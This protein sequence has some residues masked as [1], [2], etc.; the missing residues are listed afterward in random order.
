VFICNVSAEATG[1]IAI[2]MAA[3]AGS[4]VFTRYGRHVFPYGHSTTAS[5]LEKTQAGNMRKFLAAAGIGWLRCVKAN[6]NVTV[7]IFCSAL[8]YFAFAVSPTGAW[9]GHIVPKKP[10]PVIL[11]DNSMWRLQDIH[12]VGVV[13]RRVPQ[14]HYARIKN[15]MVSSPY[16]VIVSGKGYC[17]FP[18][19]SSSGRST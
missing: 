12:L 19:H 7:C 5:L 9:H 15:Q 3:A 17:V 1:S 10:K 16:S 4:G 18:A 6:L 2:P 11:Q 14:R 8:F 13:T